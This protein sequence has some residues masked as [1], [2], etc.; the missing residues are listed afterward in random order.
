MYLVS[1][2]KRTRTGFCPMAEIQAGI[3]Q[4]I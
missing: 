4:D 3:Y 1:I 2:G